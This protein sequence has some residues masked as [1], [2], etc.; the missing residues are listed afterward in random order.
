MTFGDALTHPDLIY[1]YPQVV[2]SFTFNRL[3]V[4][5]VAQVY[6]LPNGAWL[7]CFRGART[8]ASR[9]ARR[10]RTYL[11]ETKRQSGERENGLPAG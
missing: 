2:A 4:D 8:P 9:P 7:K 3:A 1:Q 5:V 6:F 10:L 11:L